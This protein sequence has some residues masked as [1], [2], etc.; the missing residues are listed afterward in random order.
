MKFT[1]ST[2]PFELYFISPVFRIRKWIF[3]NSIFTT[4]NVWISPVRVCVSSWTED[5]MIGLGLVL[6]CSSYGELKQ[7]RVSVWDQRFIIRGEVEAT[8]AGQTWLMTRWWWMKWIEENVLELV[9]GCGVSIMHGWHA[10]DYTHSEQ[11]WILAD[12]LNRS[13]KVTLQGNL[14]VFSAS[15]QH[16]VLE[17]RKR[18]D[19]GF[20]KSLISLAAMLNV[21]K[22]KFQTE[23]HWI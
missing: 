19:G 4:E 15:Q 23:K 16:T 9:E 11:Q 7:R 18:R 12:P 1:H 20:K 2:K 5:V 21:E 22:T 17:E 10:Q 8:W 3:H 6:Q 13:Y 14:S